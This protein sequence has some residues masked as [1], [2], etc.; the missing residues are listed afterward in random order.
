MT[1]P[2]SATM[3]SDACSH[4][5]AF[6]NT[7]KYTGK[8]RDYESGLDNFD[9]R[10]LGSSLGRFS[11]PDAPFADQAQTEPQSWNLYG[12]V[13]NNPLNNTDPTGN[14][15]ISTPDQPAYHDDNQGGQTCAVVNAYNAPDNRDRVASA[16]VTP[17][18]DDQIKMFAEDIG[19]IGTAELK[20]DVLLMAA[21]AAGAAADAA[22]ARTFVSATEESAAEAT[23]SLGPTRSSIMSTRPA[24]AKTA[25]GFV[26]W[27]RNLQRAGAK[28]T[29]QEA[30]EIIA[31]AK[32]L[33]VKVRLD[34]PHVGTPWNVPHLNIGE[35]NVHLEVPS[36]YSNSTVPMGH[37]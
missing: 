2:D 30:D 28:L 33:N 15:C 7:Y 23:A 8:E 16:V 36:G 3:C 37:P 9:A 31:E 12:Y 21:G 11:S 34:P 13:R 17:S 26:N 25:G 14:N 10:Y 22:I 4:S 35:A 20:Q 18:H 24:W 19:N 6:R 5:V 29:A 32:T 1:Q 27:L